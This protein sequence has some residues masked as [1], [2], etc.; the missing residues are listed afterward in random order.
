[1]KNIIRTDGT[2]ILIKSNK[3]DSDNIILIFAGFGYTL[4]QPFLY[5]SIR[6]AT[7]LGYKCIGF[8]LQYY[9]NSRFLKLKEN[10]QDEYFEND[11]ALIEKIVKDNDLHKAKIAIGKSLGTT[12]IS[13]LIKSKVFN[14]QCDFVLFT[15][16]TEWKNIIPIIISNESRTLVVGSK[17]DK[18][19]VVDNLDRIYNRKI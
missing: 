12:I 15:P 2:E 1:M 13:R 9:Q 8:D 14:R 4:D 19:Y 17:A 11:I 5:Y 3:I 10:E 16:G 6:V 18:N 7:E